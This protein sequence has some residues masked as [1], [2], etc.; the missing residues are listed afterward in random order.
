MGRTEEEVE[1][2]IIEEEFERLLK[3]YKQGGLTEGVIIDW[4]VKHK[5]YVGFKR[6]LKLKW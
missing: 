5:N 2:M 6:M 4:L 1:K 3:E